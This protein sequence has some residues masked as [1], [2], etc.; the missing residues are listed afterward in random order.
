MSSTDN[1]QASLDSN[2]VDSNQWT[3]L[4]CSNLWTN[5]SLRQARLNRN[6]GIAYNVPKQEYENKEDCL[7][8]VHRSSYFIP[9][10]HSTPVRKTDNNGKCNPSNELNINDTVTNNMDNIDKARASNSCIPSISRQIDSNFH[11]KFSSSE[12]YCQSSNNN[13]RLKKCGIRGIGCIVSLSVTDTQIKKRTQIQACSISIMIMA[14]VTISFILVNFTGNKRIFTNSSFNSNVL[15]SIIVPTDIIQNNNITYISNA[16]T[17]NIPNKT[18]DL[19]TKY[20]PNTTEA[21]EITL[22]SDIISKI[23][24]NIRTY[25]KMSDNNLRANNSSSYKPKEIN[26]RDLTQQFCRCQIDEVCM[27]NEGSGTALCRKVIDETDPTGCGGLCELE[28]EACQFVDRARGV[29]VCRLI[30]MVICG[31]DEWR[32]RN[33]LCVAASARCDGSI[34]CY[35]KSD[36]IFCDCDL[37]K[38]FRCGNAI[39]CFSNEKLCDG[40]I[41]CWDGFDEVNCTTECPQSQF[42]CTNGQCILESRFCDGFADCEDESD[43][44]EGCN[45]E[46]GAHEFR[47]NNKRCVSLSLKCNGEDNCGD[48]TDEERCF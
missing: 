22:V 43:E 20:M 4:Y 9:N 27:L 17:E 7:N 2:I 29:R 18:T 24:K 35:D 1:F 48:G 12:V 19:Y 39:S 28:T 44:P 14:I 32:C 8:I 45:K 26:N 41:D 25:P 3:S 33:G 38:H 11:Q 47:C 21:M 46:C 15:N 6:T 10:I 40:V 5:S 36:E 37:T 16:T 23:R 30:N 34:H 31:T 13:R 42:T